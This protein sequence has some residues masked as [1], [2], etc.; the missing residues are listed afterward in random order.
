MNAL[1]FFPPA[2]ALSVAHRIVVVRMVLVIFIIVFGIL[3]LSFHCRIC[4]AAA[5]SHLKIQT[6]FAP[7]CNLYPHLNLYVFYKCL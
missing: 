4:M 7:Y 6:L 5:C 1:F 2:A 3:L